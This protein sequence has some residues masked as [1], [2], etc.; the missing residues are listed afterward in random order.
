MSGELAPLEA[1]DARTL[2]DRIKIAVEAT[3]QLIAEAYTRRAWTAL[4]YSS[5]DD[6]CQR[7]F[8]SSRLRLPREER[9][10]VVASLRESGLSI[11]AIST[12]TGIDKET[13]M[14]D[15]SGNRTPAPTIRIEIEGATFDEI[16]E[17]VTGIDG[18][19]YTPPA[20]R[21]R[22][23][24]TDEQRRAREHDEHI[25]RCVSRLERFVTGAV[26]FTSLPTDPD[27]EEIL[28]GL[29]DG[30]RRLVLDYERRWL[31]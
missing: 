11:R 13:V 8:G 14:K 31:A 17:R 7:E 10:E 18:K 29:T 26:E 22:P 20:P 16:R 2:T 6:Y 12:A 5:W 21:P 23:V 3:W 9:S 15:L 19:T 1:N 4:G 24:E 28:A 27:R 30:D 25:E